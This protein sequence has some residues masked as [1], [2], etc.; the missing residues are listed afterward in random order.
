MHKARGLGKENNTIT[1]EKLQDGF[2]ICA[3][4]QGDGLSK[5]VK[6][7]RCY[8]DQRCQPQ[9]KKFG[10]KSGSLEGADEGGFSGGVFRNG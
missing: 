4:K 6:A 1:A 10:R 5:L 3:S 2:F 7:A 9:E 8:A